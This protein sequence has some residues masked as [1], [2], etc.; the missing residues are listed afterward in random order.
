MNKGRKTALQVFHGIQTGFRINGTKAFSLPQLPAEPAY[1]QCQC[2]QQ[3]ADRKAQPYGDRQQGNGLRALGNRLQHSPG[4]FGLCY[5]G[6]I[7]AQCL[8]KVLWSRIREN[9]RICDRLAV[10]FCLEQ[11]DLFCAGYRFP[12]RTAGDSVDLLVLCQLRPA[13]GCAGL[14]ILQVVAAFLCKLRQYG[15]DR[16]LIGACIRVI[17]FQRV[18]IRIARDVNQTACAHIASSC[19]WAFWNSVRF[20]AGESDASCSAFCDASAAAC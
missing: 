9:K 8:H 6:Q 14:V 5:P 4:P 1:R 13:V 15:R 3:Q 2:C 17:V 10:D 18:Q 11:S 19:S 20:S 12:V 16:S 7:G